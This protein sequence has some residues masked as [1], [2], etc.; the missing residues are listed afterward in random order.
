M[1][2]LLHLLIGA[3]AIGIA[4]GSGGDDC[5]DQSRW[6]VQQV[7]GAPASMLLLWVI[8]IGLAAIAVWQIADA[9]GGGDHRHKKKRLGPP[10]QVRR[11]GRASGRSASPP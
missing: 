9:I 10:R 5:A 7:A 2:G 1:L 11:H 4:T 3:I 6:A 8:V